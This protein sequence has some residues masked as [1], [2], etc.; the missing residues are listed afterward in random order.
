MPIRITAKVNGFRRAGIAHSKEPT[1]HADAAFTPAQLKELQAETMLTV[2]IIGAKGKPPV[3]PNPLA[4]K[5]AQIKGASTI[6]Q[7]D[8]LAKGE[9]IEGLLKAIAKRRAELS[10]KTA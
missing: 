7:L 8:A 2:E 3:V 4:E 9:T 10:P 5:A 1:D 6:E